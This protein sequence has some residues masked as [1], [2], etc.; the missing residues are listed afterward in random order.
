MRIAFITGCLEPSSDGVGDYTRLL[1]QECDRQGH[2]C[3][4]ISLNDQFLAQVHHSEIELNDRRIPL[5]RLPAN[6]T[7][8]QRVAAAQTLLTSFQ[9]DWVSLQFVPYSFQRKGIVVGLSK[10][11]R[12]LLQGQKLHVMFHEL[13]IG[14]SKSAKL[15]ERLVGR[16]Q[17][18]FI[19]GLVKQL[20]PLAVH[21]SNSTYIA[22]LKQYGITAS[23]LPLFGNLPITQQDASDWLFPELQ[24]LGLDIQPDNRDQY[25]LFGFFGTLQPVWPAEPLFTYLHQ[26]ARQY[27]R[28]II[29]LSIGDL[30]PGEQLWENLSSTYASQFVFSRL[31][32]QAAAKVSAFLNTIDF[33]VAT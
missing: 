29:I 23:R 10:R 31:G 33:G 19:L 20:Q 15:K 6:L 18:F 1:A 8:N 28:K 30:G 4:L 21:T 3:C 13:W 22:M 17:K 2:D 24:K 7:W 27:H 32:K 16:V 26:A 14:A 12:Q 11:L 25:W 9:P 5:L